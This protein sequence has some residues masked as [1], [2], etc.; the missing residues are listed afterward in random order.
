MVAWYFATAL[1]KQPEDIMPYFE[2]KILEPWTHNKAIQKRLKASYPD[3]LDESAILLVGKVGLE[4]T[5]FLRH[6]FTVR[7]LHQ[8]GALTHVSSLIFG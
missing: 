4:P 5:A 1:A 2:K 8:F 3:L 6:G 7:C